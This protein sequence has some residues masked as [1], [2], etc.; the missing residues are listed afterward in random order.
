MHG[1]RV[2]IICFVI[3]NRVCRLWVVRVGEDDGELIQTQTGHA[4]KAASAAP[5]ATAHWGGRVLGGAGGGAAGTAHR[6][7]ARVRPVVPVPYLKP[8]PK[9]HPKPERK[10]RVCSTPLKC[11]GHSSK[12]V[13]HSS[14]CVEHSPKCVGHSS[15][16]GW[17]RRNCGSTSR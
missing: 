6:R 14:K 3:H 9:P 11:V 8:Y 5:R 13:G 15:A 12:F 10:T 7:H 1:G 16:G 2:Y 17:R 4:E